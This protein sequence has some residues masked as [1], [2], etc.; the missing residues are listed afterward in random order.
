VGKKKK[1]IKFFQN[2]E[3]VEG[4]F[5]FADN[6]PAKHERRRPKLRRRRHVSF[7]FGVGRRVVGRRLL[8]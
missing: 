8:D 2:V 7:T 4:T 5:N 1:V 6:Q 3:E